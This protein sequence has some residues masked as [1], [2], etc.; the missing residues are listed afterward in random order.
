MHNH[1]EKSK[2]NRS[3]LSHVM[4][5]YFFL[6]SLPFV[7]ILGSGFAGESLIFNIALYKN[8][9]LKNDII[10]FILLFLSDVTSLYVCLDFFRK[11]SQFR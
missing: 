10:A 2:I 6:F 1:D 8:F 5:G 3:V 9:L 7:H 4:Y 11:I